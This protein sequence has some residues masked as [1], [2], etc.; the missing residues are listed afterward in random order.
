MA[1]CIVHPMD[2]LKNRMQLQGEGARFKEH[3]TSLHLL[4]NVVQREGF[5]AVY[6][7]ITA[8]WLRQATYATARLGLYT[9]LFEKL[10]N[11]D[12]QTGKVKPPSFNE[13]ILI[14]AV[15]GGVG[16]ACGNPAEVCLIRMT[17]DGRLPPEQRRNYR[18]V[19]HALF[20]VITDEGIGGI[21]RVHFHSI[22]VYFILYCFIS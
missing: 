12:Q 22:K 1:T 8:G 6:S 7:G 2:V 21:F 20:R 9:I 4:A 16:G 15:A 5:G 10:S 18:H 13:K 3:K 14:A 11:R 17:T 19:F